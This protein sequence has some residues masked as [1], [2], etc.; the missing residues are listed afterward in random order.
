MS[1]L[2]GEYLYYG[3]TSYSWLNTTDVS[4]KPVANILLV[5]DRGL[6]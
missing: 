4:K 5:E 2:L 3:M 6:S 1:F